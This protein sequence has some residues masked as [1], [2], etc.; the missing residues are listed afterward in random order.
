MRDV[1]QTSKEAYARTGAVRE[2]QA[3]T[4]VRVLREQHRDGMG[5]NYLSGQQIAE[6]CE[7]SYVQIMKHTRN[8]QRAGQIQA[9]AYTVTNLSGQQAEQFRWLSDT[10]APAAPRKPT[11]AERIEKA[12]QALVDIQVPGCMGK[13]MQA[14]AEALR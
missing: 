11:R 12:A 8:L 10:P 2:T 13:R 1:P 14:L 9:S 5:Q 6:R 4:I 7:L 3:Q